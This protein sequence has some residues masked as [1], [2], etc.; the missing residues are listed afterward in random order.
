MTRS[1]LLPKVIGLGTWGLITF[2]L[3]GALVAPFTLAWLV[4]LFNAYWLV[5]SSMLGV[6]SVVSFI[7]LRR[8][9]RT[10]WL[11]AV[12]GVSGFDQLHHVVVIPTYKEPDAILA[13]TLD[14][15]VRQDFPSKRI[16]VVL[17]FEARDAGSGPRAARLL[18][19]YRAH[20][21]QM[22]ALPLETGALGNGVDADSSGAERIED[23]SPI[24]PEAP[25]P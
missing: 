2:P 5:R 16:A 9:E 11:G 21:G 24:Q 10:D 3:W 8:S 18:A 6:G 1:D 25:A 19:R 12:R 7:R 4:L 17:A 13:E 14:H 20:F 22:W 23:L 15:L